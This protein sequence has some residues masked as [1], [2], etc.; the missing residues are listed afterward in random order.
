MQEAPEDS[1]SS[2]GVISGHIAAEMPSPGER[3]E[4]AADNRPVPEVSIVLPVHNEG[5]RLCQ[6]LAAIR[7]TVHLSYEA[8]VVN[9]ASTDSG[10]DALRADPPPFENLVLLDLPKRHGVAAARNLGAGR[11]GA[12]VLVAMDAHC[13]PR[14]GWL[15][16]LLEELHK[17]GVGIAAPQIGSLECPAATTFGLTIRDRELGVDWLHR[18]EKNP[19]PVPMAGCACMVMTREFFEAAGRF[20]AMRSY[21]MEDVELCI[22]AWLLGYSVIMVPDAEVGHWFKKEP[23]PVGWHDYVYNRLRTAVLH[24]D[25]E[26]LRRIL[27]ALQAKPAFSD[28][29]ASLLVSDIWE[30]RRQVRQNRK[31]DADWF[32]REF[33]I[34]L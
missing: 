34:A 12:P 4:P 8:I 21:G 30:R 26:P 13:I 25:G 28:A 6:T 14:R 3:S 18:R 20:D 32:C 10:C 19:Y 33:E 5:P 24:F 16:K 2:G 17:P 9:D 29:V 11:A 15:E 22:R 7:D 1:F 31:R 27:A 23:F